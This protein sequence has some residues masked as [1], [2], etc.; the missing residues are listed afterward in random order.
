MTA[1]AVCRKW[2]PGYDYV[3]SWPGSVHG[4]IVR[5]TGYVE[6]DDGVN[7]DHQL[8]CSHGAIWSCGWLRLTVASRLRL[9][10][11]RHRRPRREDRALG[12]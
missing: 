11:D 7:H 3:S 9:A 10:R 4:A 8:I 2:P 6:C 12:P 1:L 5:V